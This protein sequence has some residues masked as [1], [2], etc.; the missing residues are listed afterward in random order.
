MTSQNVVLFIFAISISI[1]PA[2]VI[3]HR[4]SRWLDCRNK[5]RKIAEFIEQSADK[6]IKTKDGPI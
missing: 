6:Q 5:K 3:F 2:I 1:I 4:L